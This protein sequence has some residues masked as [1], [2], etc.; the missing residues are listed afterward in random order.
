MRLAYGRLRTDVIALACGYPVFVLLL[1]TCLIWRD[2]YWQL[3]VQVCALLALAMLVFLALV[4]LV[5]TLVSATWGV[6]LLIVWVLLLVAA[7]PV[8]IGNTSNPKM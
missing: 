5:I 6:L 2:H 7:R 8:W 3:T 1:A 4:I